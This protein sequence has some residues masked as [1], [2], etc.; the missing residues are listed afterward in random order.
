MPGP[1]F[2]STSW[3]SCRLRASGCQGLRRLGKIGRWWKRT[4]TGH[5]SIQLGQNFHG[6]SQPISLQGLST[7]LSVLNSHLNEQETDPVNPDVRQLWQSEAFS[8]LIRMYISFGYVKYFGV[9]DWLGHDLDES[10]KV[11]WICSW[12]PDD[13]LEK[14]KAKSTVD[15][16]IIGD[17]TLYFLSRSVAAANVDLRN[18]TASWLT[19]CP[20]SGRCYTCC[21]W[22]HVSPVSVCYFPCGESRRHPKQKS[23]AE[24]TW[25]STSKNQ[26]TRDQTCPNLFSGSVQPMILS[27]C[28]WQDFWIW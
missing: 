8:Q 16:A 22:K 27:G 21:I 28:T 3:K 1:S 19:S 14:W 20:L 18:K 12:N 26:T 5:P 4:C 25:L 2:R 6:L 13:R 9:D 10:R 23:A 11:I 24:C 17:R 7:E 15:E